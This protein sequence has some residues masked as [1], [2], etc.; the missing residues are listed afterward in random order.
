MKD[1]YLIMGVE[2]TATEREIKRTYRRLAVQFHP[3]KNPTTE[4]EARFK[5]INE[6]YMVL[7]D[8]EARAAYD[9]RLDN[10]AFYSLKDAQPWHRDP[11]YRR[12]T[13]RRPSSSPSERTLFMQSM[14]KYSRLLFYF[15]CFWCLVLLVDYA[16]PSNVQHEVVIS[17][18]S[19]LSRL[20][21]RESVDLLVTDNKHHFNVSPSEM[22]HFPKGST[23]HIYT[24]SLL[25]AVV[26]LENHDRTFIVNNLATIYR[27]FSFAPIMLLLTCSAGLLIRKGVEFHVNLGIVVFLLMILNIIFLFTSQL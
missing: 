24:S 11:A 1:Y 2:R 12:A 5:E 23:L 20:V 15:G 4:A 8:T 26:K 18:I 22:R 19:K 6:A 27:N 10:P 13:S 25:S 9:E 17:D 21:T 3:D 7:S 16:L 14:L